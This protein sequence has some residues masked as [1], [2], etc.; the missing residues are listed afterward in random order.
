MG[1]VGT[2]ETEVSSPAASVAKVAPEAVP[3]RYPAESYEKDV[4]VPF[5]VSVV[6]SPAPL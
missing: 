3:F 5:R 4:A 2:P 1:E 6:R